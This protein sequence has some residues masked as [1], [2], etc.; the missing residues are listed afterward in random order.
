MAGSQQTIGQSMLQQIM[1]MIAMQSLTERSSSDESNKKKGG[2]GGNKIVSL[3]VLD[4]ITKSTPFI[5]GILTQFFH[6]KMKE[7]SN[8]LYEMMRTGDAAG[9]KKGSIT[10]TREISES[11]N[12]TDETFDALLTYAS[13]LPQARF[14]KRLQN[15]MYIIETSN[16]ISIGDSIYFRRIP[17]NSDT[18][19]MVEVFS[20]DKTIVQIHDFLTMIE[21]KWKTT[22]NNQ[23]GRNIYYFDEISPKSGSERSLPK[24]INIHF[25]MYPLYTNKSL[26]NVFGRPMQNVRRR[27]NF[28]INNKTWYEDKGV[29]Y[30][31]GLLLHGDPG[32]GKTSLAKA[33]AKDT[34]RHIV[35]L[36]LSK[37]T[38]VRQLHNLFYSGSVAVMHESNN[39]VMYQIPIDKIII[40][41]EDIDCLSDIVIDRSKRF[42]HGKNQNSKQ[43]TETQHACAVEGGLLIDELLKC[44]WSNS[45]GQKKLITGLNLLKDNNLKKMKS[46]NMVSKTDM[47]GMRTNSNGNGEGDGEEKINLS[48]LLNV[49]DGIL[50][51][52]GRIVIMTTNHPEHLDAALIRPGRIDAIVHFTKSSREDTIEMIES[53][54]ST[55]ITNEL[56]QCIPEGV[57]TPAEVAQIIFE[58]MESDVEEIVDKLAAAA[59]MKQQPPVVE[60]FDEE[61]S[62]VDVDV[63]VHVDTNSENLK[64]AESN[65]IDDKIKSKN[66]IDKIF[67]I[68]Q[69]SSSVFNK[70]P[71]AA[72]EF[73][74]DYVEI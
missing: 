55:T 71:V 47:N 26:A 56:Y 6:R 16:D 13:D 38:T 63:H 46:F 34:N 4:I 12:G 24:Q 28:F 15:G 40:M 10:L 22:R 70:E 25:A 5:G 3:I 45:E 36:K 37:N 58:N 49:L 67:E 60:D 65:T 74:I 7:R 52:P 39:V 64:C 31:L 68:P 19:M 51:T 17:N 53:L 44:D 30:T 59:E 73:E 69:Q 66:D 23:L 57:F 43:D 32:C 35:N 20:Y 11:R 2:G 62:D 14:I 8:R 54:C 61:D 18:H 29:P 50:E 33:L 27:I 48:T 21:Q 72:N 1:P 41:I 9:S 42:N